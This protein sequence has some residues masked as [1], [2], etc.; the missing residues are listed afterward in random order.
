MFRKHPASVIA[1]TSFAIAIVGIVNNM[2]IETHDFSVMTYKEMLNPFYLDWVFSG[3]SLRV[4][5][6]NYVNSFFDLLLILG[7]IAFVAS[8][9]KQSRLIR[10]VFS[11]IFLSNALAFANPIVLF[12]FKSY[13][14]IWIKHLPREILYYLINVCW[15]Y[16]SLKTLNYLKKA[17]T[18]KQEVFT[19]GEHTQSSFVKA[20]NWQRVLHPIADFIVTIVLF[21]QMLG[22][23]INYDADPLFRSMVR[24]N[25]G[26]AEKN[27]VSIIIGLWVIYYLL[28]EAVLGGSPA[29]FLTKTRVIDYNGAKPSFKKIT[30]RTLLRLVPFEAVSFFTSDGWHDKWSETLVVKEESLDDPS[31]ENPIIY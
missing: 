29:K 13:F 1:I 9:Y 4:N 23:F 30:I 19:E 15:I 10:F 5:G 3:H 17:H 6:Y 11:I 8:G 27:V 25:E 26:W 22:L 16:L 2:F 31:P 21:S 24:E 14:P 12:A 18:L 28:S 7:A 20:P